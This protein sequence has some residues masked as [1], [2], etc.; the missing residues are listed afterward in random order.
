MR[1]VNQAYAIATSTKIDLSNFKLPERLTDDVFKR[2]PRK[3]KSSEDMF[4]ETQEKG[5]P[6]EERVEDQK[7]VDN[8]ILPE[9]SKVPHLKKY[10]KT[11][12]SLRYGQFPHEMKF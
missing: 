5:K 11:L 2:T 6:S 12:F 1:R 8:Q 7:T 10:M 4:Q 3:K 9:I